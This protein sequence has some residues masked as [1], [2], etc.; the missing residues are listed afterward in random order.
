MAATDRAMSDRRR[1]D[2]RMMVQRTLLG[3]AAVLFTST[4]ALAAPV[5]TGILQ[6]SGCLPGSLYE[7]MTFNDATDIVFGSPVNLGPTALG[8]SYIQGD[9]TFAF[10]T[11]NVFTM[12]VTSPP[13]YSLIAFQVSGVFLNSP[14][15]A[16]TYTFVG[17]VTGLLGSVVAG[18]PAGLTYTL[19]GS[20]LATGLFGSCEGFQG[21]VALNAFQPEPTPTSPSGC[22]GAAC[23][24]TVTPPPTDIVNS[25]T[26]QTVTVAA[27]VSF[28]VV[29]AGG[30]T[31]VSAVSNVTGQLAANFAF[32]QGATYLDIST[33]AAY[34]TSSAP[35]EVCVDYTLAG[36]VADPSNLRLM[37]L[38]G[39]VWVNV[40][41]RID[42]ATDTICGLTSSLSPFGVA[43]QTACTADTECNDTNP[44]TVDTC[45]AGTCAHA[46]G[47][48]G[49]ECRP[50]AEVC[51]VAESCDGVASACPADAFAEAGTA[52]AGGTCDGAGSCTAPTTTT[53]TT[54]TTST[55]GAVCGNGTV[56]AGE[57]C[58]DGPTNGQ[59]E[60]C[61]SGTCQPKPAGTAC[62]DDG[63]LCTTDICNATTTC[64]HTLEPAPVCATPTVAK[65]ASLLLQSIPGNN[66][67]QFKWGKGPMVPLID[68]GTPGSEL[69]RLCVYDQTGPDSYALVLRASPSV[70]GG[71]VWT[72]SPTGWKFKSLMGAPDGI[73]GV[74]L[75]AGTVP[76]KAKVQVKAKK[77]N[78]SLS[79]LPL[80]SN[81]H[82]VA[83]FKTSQGKCWGAI[84]STP[85][86]N[87]PTGFKAKSD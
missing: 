56:E 79:A 13:D 12:N 10:G 29:T 18:L 71:G 58:D 5:G 19:D 34:D 41:S 80:Q 78:P 75:K 86:V 7:T 83:Q 45:T 62:A 14:D 30:A 2:D 54:T 66:R 82:V 72:G 33:T 53:T 16:Y 1:K 27:T 4:I 9:G 47:N 68:F 15:P 52:C 28:P 73:T 22:S 85:T 11:P 21:P 31:T 87:M 37:H 46:A 32:N 59:I 3:I 6:V 76:L 44:C 64:V 35:I 84:F 60:S 48:A 42:S 61:C 67:A 55:V 26:G 17:D 23:Q 51:D 8:S 25:Q 57:Q 24:V 69:T 40:T 36:A 38:E 43:V 50:A 39:G 20:V 81:P 65:A 74:V 70:S 77:G 63:D 49:T